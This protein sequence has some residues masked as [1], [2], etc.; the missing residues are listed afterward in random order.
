[1]KSTPT[2][3]QIG[4][5]KIIRKYDPVKDEIIYKADHYSLLFLIP[6]HLIRVI[7]LTMS[8]V[9]LIIIL[10]TFIEE[11]TLDPD[12]VP[13][14]VHQA[15][16]LVYKYF[17]ALNLS[18]LLDFDTA[19]IPPHSQRYPQ[20]DAN[21]TLDLYMSQFTENSDELTPTLVHK[22]VPILF[23]RPLL[24]FLIFAA[25]ISYIRRHTI[26]YEELTINKKDKTCMYK[27]YN[28]VNMLLSSHIIPTSATRVFIHEYITFASV[29]YVLCICDEGTASLPSMSHS[30]KQLDTLSKITYPLSPHEKQFEDKL[31]KEKDSNS[32]TTQLYHSNSFNN[33]L[34]YK[35]QTVQTIHQI[36]SVCRSDQNLVGYYQTK[37]TIPLVSGPQSSTTMIGIVP[38]FIPQ[39]LRFND[40]KTIYLDLK[41]LFKP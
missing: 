40:I 27:S 9:N 39:K 6:I 22:T 12:T 18:A 2:T 1:M 20:F 8:I 28:G 32:S 37:P 21:S 30:I 17:S 25:I 19:I 41:Q 35:T 31:Q 5:S 3:A 38:L 33:D 29:Y 11:L 16:G 4:S 10:P 7:T 26:R 34:H 36:L 23:F 13:K 14:L 24:L 15:A